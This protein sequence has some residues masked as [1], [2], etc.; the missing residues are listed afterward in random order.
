VEIQLNK[1][2]ENKPHPKLRVVHLRYAQTQNIS[3]PNQLN[4]GDLIPSTIVLCHAVLWL[5]FLLKTHSTGYA[6]WYS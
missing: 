6:R 3:S 1:R 2:N 4:T 5:W